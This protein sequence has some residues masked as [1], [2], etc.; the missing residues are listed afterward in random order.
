MSASSEVRV[1]PASPSLG[2]FIKRTWY[3]LIGGAVALCALWYWWYFYAFTDEYY[4]PL[5]PIPYSHK[6][7]AGQLGLDCQYCHF[8]AARGKHAGVPPLS[9]CLGCHDP[10][11]GAAGAGLPGVE[12]M[13]SMV[14]DSD[15][16]VRPAY[17][18]TDYD[19]GYDG[20]DAI[21]SGGAVHWERVHKLPDHV[22][23]RHEW[24][25]KAGI[26]C[27]TCHGPIE[28]MEV[29]QQYAPLTMGW[30]IDCHRNNNYVGGPDFDGSDESFTVGQANYD[31]LRARIR[32]DRVPDMVERTVAG[33]DHGHADHADAD[34]DGYPPTT[35]EH[36]QAVVDDL[37]TDA[38]GKRYP[39]LRGIFSLKEGPSA[40]RRLSVDDQLYSYDFL[41]DAQAEALR[42]A[43]RVNAERGLDALPRWR[44]PDLPSIHAQF[45]NTFTDA[46]GNPASW[47]EVTKDMTPAERNHFVKKQIRRFVSYQNA[48]TQCN[49]CHQ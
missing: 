3:L 1:L 27:Q 2:A 6:L 33:S 41:T 36:R 35:A 39:Q 37:L 43:F 32:P 49:T 22:Y 11:Q 8:N 42:E 18:D 20:D 44:I 4:A 9:V 40:P 24:H 23:F 46:D 19:N 45:Y 15:G 21:M 5:Q 10:Q 13:L 16:E 31:V 12:R 25:V 29:V 47:D 17:Q 14:L 34:A 30:C 7:H 28:E 48:S 26:A 38:D